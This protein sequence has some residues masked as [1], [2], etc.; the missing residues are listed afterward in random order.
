[1]LP[2]LLLLFVNAVGLPMG[3]SPEPV[4]FPHFPDRMHAY[5]WRNWTLVPTDRLASVVGAK[6]EDIIALGKA[7]GLSDPPTV[8]EDQLARSYVTIIRR[9]W[10]LLPYEQIAEL[11]KWSIDE[12]DYALREGDG[13]LWWMGGYKPKLEPLRYAAPNEAA[14]AREAEIART[15]HETFPESVDKTH[16]PLF[17]FVDRLSKSQ[18]P[19]ER[20]SPDWPP[21]SP[22][23]NS[24]FSPRYCFSYFGAFRDP[25]NGKQ[26]P[27]PNGY[28]DLL[29]A[30]GVDGVWLHE[31]HYHLAPFPWDPS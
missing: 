17:S 15:I 19:R 28:L 11:L 21:P 31:P 23:T 27:Y 13:L 24:T 1:M 2:A 29:R 8:S 5:V 3:W 16:D 4:P 18:A 7:M 26:D 30:C 12:M 20:Q 6:S 10:H 25:L 14:I 9:N 22:P